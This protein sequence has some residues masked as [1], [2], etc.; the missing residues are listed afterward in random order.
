MAKVTN[1]GNSSANRHKFQQQK[2]G[3]ADI[4]DNEFGTE[5]YPGVKETDQK[6]EQGAKQQRKR[7][8]EPKSAKHGRNHA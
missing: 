8:N 1:K 4:P 6:K 2:A 3:A 7:R 5:M